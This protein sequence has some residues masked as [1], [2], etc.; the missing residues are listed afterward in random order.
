MSRKQNCVYLVVRESVTFVDEFPVFIQAFDE[1]ED[2]N[3]MVKQWNETEKWFVEQN[4]A[5][6]YRYNF[7]VRTVWL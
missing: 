1:A 7:Y 5:G 3:A 6:N 2:A 4:F